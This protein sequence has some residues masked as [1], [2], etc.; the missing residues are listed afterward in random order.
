MLDLQPSALVHF[1]LEP[2]GYL[3]HHWHVSHGLITHI[4]FDKYPGP[5]PFHDANGLID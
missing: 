4:G 2:L 3:L 5:Y 1:N